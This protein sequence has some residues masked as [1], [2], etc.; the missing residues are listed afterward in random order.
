MSRP[1]LILLGAWL[2]GIAYAFPGYMNWDAC[3]QET[4]ARAGAYGDAHP[5]LMAVLWRLV[6]QVVH[7]PFGMLVIQT[8]LF[9]WGLYEV[10]RRRFEPRTAAWIAAALFVF[11]PILTPMAVVWKD[12]Q[13][14]GFL[15]AG[16]MLAL[17]ASWS[18]R[19]LG[20]ALLF[21]GV[22]VRHNAPL[23]LPPLCLFVVAS[24]GLQRKWLVIVAG[25]GLAL[26]VSL[27]ALQVD[28]KLG[29]PEHLWARTIAVYDIAGTL[30]REE[31][32]SDEE[33]RAELLGV[34]ILVDG[35][36]QKKMCARYNSRAVFTIIFGEGRIFGAAPDPDEVRARRAAWERVVRLH[37]AAYLAHRWSVMR[38]VVGLTALDPWEP[39]CQEFG[40]NHDEMAA[41]SE[42]HSQSAFQVWYGE[43]AVRLAR[44]VA[45]RPWAYAV[46]GLAILG[47]AF[48]RRDGWLAAWLI[49]GMVYEA[50]YFIGAPSPDYRYSHWL[51]VCCCIAAITVFGERVRA[52]KRA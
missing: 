42:A 8:S 15:L 33:I 36:L 44:T 6:E 27:A 25:L 49:S 47:Y 31:P 24:W 50:S 35:D 13:M 30:C 21:M 3:S 20:I 19:A 9:L 26:A 1:R 45:Y 41:L 11:P 37:P 29:A 32:M 2:F 5:P 51:V 17:R 14:A 10:F 43:W 52:G 48:L 40:A 22:G 38:E 16:F 18:A 12:A 46:L 28:A 4:Q 7:G 23:A 39:A 34:P